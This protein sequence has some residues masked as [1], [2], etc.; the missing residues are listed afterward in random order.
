MRIEAYKKI[1]QIMSLHVTKGFIWSQ[2]ASEIIFLKCLMFLDDQ[3]VDQKDGV[4]SPRTHT[5]NGRVRTGTQMSWFLCIL[6]L[7][8][9]NSTCVSP[10][11][12]DLPS[13]ILFKFQVAWVLVPG[14]DL[15][16]RRKTSVSPWISI[17]EARKCIPRKHF[18]IWIL[19]HLTVS[20]CHPVFESLEI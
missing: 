1:N 14:G 5:S 12:S 15:P 18:F 3:S 9:K 4:T 19:S 2:I 17:S 11:L 10:P 16:F 8:G 7:L 20:A 6:V 13:P